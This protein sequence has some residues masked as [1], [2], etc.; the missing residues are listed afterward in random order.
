[1]NQML[2][3]HLTLRAPPA[4][5]APETIASLEVRCDALGLSPVSGLLSDPLKDGEREQLRWYLEEYWKW[6]FEQFK[7][8][9]KGIE[10]LLGEIGQR[11][12]QQLSFNTNAD[13]ILQAWSTTE[14]N[15]RQI[16]LFSEVPAAFTLPWEL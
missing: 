8:R 12:Y 16:S 7:E 11:F 2:D 6:P 10:R 13:R 4:G 3:L 1:M 14:T 9:A 5:A 15:Q